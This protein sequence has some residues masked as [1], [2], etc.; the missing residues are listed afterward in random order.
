VYAFDSTLGLRDN[1]SVN[2]LGA[3]LSQASTTITGEL[4]GSFGSC[5][6]R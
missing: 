3:F 5:I 4:G 2:N 6:A 1:A